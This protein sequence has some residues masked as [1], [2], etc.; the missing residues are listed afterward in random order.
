MAVDCKSIKM[1]RRGEGEE[2]SFSFYFAGAS[3]GASAA[4]D[5]GKEGTF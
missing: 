2:I 3:A 1:F 5:A 4:P